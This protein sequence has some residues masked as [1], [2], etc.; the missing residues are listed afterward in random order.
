MAAPD[1]REVV[2]FLGCWSRLDLEAALAAITDDA[3]FQADLKSPPAVGRAAIREVWTRYFGM[4]R[5]YR[6]ETRYLLS[7]GGVVMLER[8]E[9]FGALDGVVLELP[10]VGV[11][12]VKAGR[13][14]AWRDYWDTSMMRPQPGAAA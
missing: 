13:I 2:D 7:A 14:A 1:E 12:E 5:S 8:M 10:I 3:V 9:W 6:F 4:M 11:F